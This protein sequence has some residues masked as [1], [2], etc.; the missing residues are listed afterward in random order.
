MSFNP[1]LG[2]C[3]VDALVLACETAGIGHRI[4]WSRWT[5]S[6]AGKAPRGGKTRL[7]ALANQDALE[8]FCI[9]TF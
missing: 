9:T 2:L 4:G 1:S 8:F 3:S 5:A 7:G 6:G